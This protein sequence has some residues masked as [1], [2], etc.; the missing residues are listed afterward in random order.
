M[1][2]YNKQT[3]GDG[4]GQGSLE[5]CNPWAGKESDMTELLNDNSKELARVRVRG[6]GAKAR[7]VHL[8][9]HTGVLGLT[10]EKK[11]WG[12]SEQESKNV[13]QPKS[14]GEECRY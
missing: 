3:P 14:Q 9:G 4:E 12:R 10:E 13:E 5:Y 2:G 8:G 11:K 6:R 7:T 1:R